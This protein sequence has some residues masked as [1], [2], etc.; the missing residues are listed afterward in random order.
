MKLARR[1]RRREVRLS[2]DLAQAGDLD[3][4]F[5]LDLPDFSHKFISAFDLDQHI[6]MVIFAGCDQ[7]AWLEGEQVIYAH[8]GLREEGPHFHRGGIEA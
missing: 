3:R 8:A 1:R 2:G 5:A 7:I 6:R 4:P